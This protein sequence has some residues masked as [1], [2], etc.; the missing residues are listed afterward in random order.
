MIEK[1]KL[2]IEAEQAHGR[3][4]YGGDPKNL[5]HD[6]NLLWRVWHECIAD[7]NH[8]AE[9]ATPM[10]RRQHLVKVAGLAISAIEAFD[11]NRKKREGG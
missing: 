4:K 11:R 6:D 2:Q 10:E 3:E 7:H 8:R 9:L 5:A 1:L